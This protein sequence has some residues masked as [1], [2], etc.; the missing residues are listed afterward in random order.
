[1]NLRK[2]ILFF[3][4]LLFVMPLSAHAGWRFVSP[5]P[6][7]RYEHDA[8]LGPDGK[9]YV[10]GGFV[11]YEHNGKYSNVVY[12]PK[13]DTWNYLRPVPGG[14]NFD[15]YYYYDP[16]RK[17]WRRVKK[18][19]RGQTVPKTL[20]GKMVRNTNFE[21]IGDGV[22]LAT[23]K[24][25]IIYWLGGKRILTTPG[26]NIVL[27]FD[28][29]KGLWP[30]VGYKRF[31]YSSSSYRD[32]TIF[33]TNMPSMLER[34]LDHE[35]VVTSDGK[36]YVLG[37]RRY[38]V[39]PT[40]DGF[41]RTGEVDV[42]DTVECYDPQT[43]KWEYKKPMPAKRFL[44][45]AMVGPDDKIYVFGGAGGWPWDKSMPVLDTTDV[46]D[47]KTDTWSSRKPMPER[48]ES[49]SGALGSNGRMY[50]M[51]GGK[52]PYTPPLNDVFIYDPV[53]DTWERG[54]SMK[55][56]RAL[57]AAVGTPD[58]KIYAIGGT[59]A[60][61]YENVRPLNIFLPKKAELYTGKVQK[62]VEVLDISD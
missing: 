48:R 49:H 31:Y 21:R 38:V 53:K 13:N 16:I 55:L 6:H 7:A 15:C 27:P 11:W 56:P 37:G 5:M 30:E 58:G 52:G 54:P 23:G 33:K 45:A 1:M 20:L 35:A 60:G 29:I 51:G 17:K 9:I 42:S 22:A 18:N 41:R 43:N 4:I 3:A 24:D 50:I 61:A 14:F 26:E 10:M 28:P 8:T 19:I 32:K 40:G 59:D 47:S 25:G 2:H 46:Y 44:F 62:T 12:D 39:T 36:I 34:R 57:F